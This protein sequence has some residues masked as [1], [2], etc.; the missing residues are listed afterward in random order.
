MAAWMCRRKYHLVYEQGKADISS[1]ITRDYYQAE[2]S[3]IME[4][5]LGFI[6]R[7]IPAVPS[8]HSQSI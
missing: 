1:I 6:K 3:E 4:R 7:M 2:E 5:I 8:C